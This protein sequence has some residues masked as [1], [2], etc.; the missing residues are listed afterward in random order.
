MNKTAKLTILLTVG[1]LVTVVPG[2]LLL[3]DYSNDS[4]PPGDPLLVW[5]LESSI[6]RARD[7]H[8]LLVFVHPRCPCS[9]ATLRE[10]GRIT[11]RC[12]EGLTVHV[13]IYVPSNEPD[14]WSR[15]DLYAQ[16]HAI[17]GVEVRMDT[18]GREAVRFG[19]VTSGHALLYDPDGKLVFSGGITAGRGHEGDN[20]GHSAIVEAIRSGKTPQSRAPVFG[21]IIVEPDG[22]LTPTA[23]EPLE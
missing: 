7:R 12:G 11:A 21:C 4:G 1:W 20:V 18:V 22:A 3:T 23:G 8:S 2:M 13:L 14:D 10:L 6:E 17:P 5:P 15:T 9:R 19:T 16:A